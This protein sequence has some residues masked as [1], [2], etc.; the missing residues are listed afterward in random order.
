MNQPVPRIF[1]ELLQTIP[2]CGQIRSMR[3]ASFARLAR[4]QTPGKCTQKLVPS[5]VPHLAFRPVIVGP[6][7]LQVSCLLD[8][9]GLLSGPLKSIAMLLGC[10]QHAGTEVADGRY[11]LHARCSHA[12]LEGMALSF[13]GQ[14]IHS[15]VYS[16]LLKA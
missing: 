16:C 1:S 15:S 12:P 4:S 9:C 13:Q 8:S 14:R 10:V 3:P 6:G 5:T 7:L 2:V 11:R